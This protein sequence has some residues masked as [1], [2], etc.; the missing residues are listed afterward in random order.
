MKYRVIDFFVDLYD[1]NHIYNIGDEY[2]RSGGKQPSKIRIASLL[3]DRNKQSRPL[4]EIVNNDPAAAAQDEVE[5][6]NAAAPDETSK[7]GD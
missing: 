4:I 2:P 1:G 3:S 5:Q 6:E 7:A